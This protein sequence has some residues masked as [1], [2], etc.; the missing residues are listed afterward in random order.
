MQKNDLKVFNDWF[1]DYI[2][3]FYGSDDY[4]NANLE[5]KEVH[6][7]HVVNE[8]KYIA[9]G[10][11]LNEKD[12]LLAETI[13]LFHDLG[14]FEQF[15]KY[16][17]YSDHKS[18]NHSN[19]AIRVLEEEKIL[20]ILPKNEQKLIITAIRHHNAKD[21]PNDL[22]SNQL[23]HTRLVRDADKLDIY[24]V[25]LDK[26]LNF[27]DDKENFNLELEFPDDPWYSDNIIEAI[28]K[29]KQAHYHHLNTL[30]DMK[31]LILAMIYDVNFTP[32]F[33]KI[34]QKGYIQSFFEIL[35]RDKTTQKLNKKLTD[36]VNKKLKQKRAGVRPP[37]YPR[38]NMKHQRSKT[39]SKPG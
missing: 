22:D 12:S 31:L 39:N 8:A 23:L 10:I 36:Y 30:S 35:P 20:N 15:T 37:I 13:A 4:I 18:E 28:L 16:K 1:Y 2:G 9:S 3:N 26:Y 27:Y 24:R 5:L 17:T 32:T 25:L 7:T 19:I 14:R 6:T 38:H 33:Q 21:L 34:R 29:E 11:G